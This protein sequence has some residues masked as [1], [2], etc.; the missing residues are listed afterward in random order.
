[1]LPG[2]G[3]DINMDLAAKHPLGPIRGGG[4]Y[5]TDR[6]L[7]GTV[8]KPE[9]APVGLR[10]TLQGLRSPYP[11]GVRRNTRACRGCPIRAPV[12]FLVLIHLEL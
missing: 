10:S 5:K 9:R 3:L 11:P 1:M 12:I 6:T 2:M 4:A 7:D 8:T